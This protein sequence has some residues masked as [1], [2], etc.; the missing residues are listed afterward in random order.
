VAIYR[1]PADRSKVTRY[2]NLLRTRSYAISTGMAHLN[3]QLIP[4]PV[5]RFAQILSPAPVRASVFLDEDEWSIQNGALG[6]EPLRTGQK[7]Y[8]NLPASRHSRGCNL[9]FAD[10]HAEYWRWLDS[11]IIQ[12][13]GIIRTR[14]LASPGDYIVR[15]D[16]TVQDRDLP[17]LQA[18]VPPGWP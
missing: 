18:T 7:A 1:C 3:P 2:P 14:Y 9:S 11:Q 5:Y 8:W 16:T 10:G 12:A 13:S 17:R 4:Y 6:I 15:V